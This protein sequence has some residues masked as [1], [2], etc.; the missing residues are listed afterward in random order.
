M[1]RPTSPAPPTTGRS[2]T[3]SCA[4]P[5]RSASAWRGSPASSPLEPARARLDRRGG[6]PRRADLPLRR[7]GALPR[8]RAP[9]RIG[10]RVEGGAPPRAALRRAPRQALYVPVDDAP[11]LALLR[12]GR[13]ARVFGY[14]LLRAAR[15]R[16]DRARAGLLRLG[17]R[18]PAAA[19]LKRQAPL[20]ARRERSHAAA[21]GR[22]LTTMMPTMRSVRFARTHGMFPKK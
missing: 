4:S 18:L 6:D 9:R 16:G 19:R 2:P 12:R 5:S 8:A 20:A 11:R 10:A 1:A 22:R 17:G 21:S 14:R 7:V 3:R 15:C 13:R